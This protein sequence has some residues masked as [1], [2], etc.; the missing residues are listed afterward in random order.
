MSLTRSSTGEFWNDT[1]SPDIIR[2][3]QEY[4]SALRASPV[5]R[6][7]PREYLPSDPAERPAALLAL[8]RVDLAQRWQASQRVSIE[9]YRDRYP[10]L[11]GEA[12]VTLIYEEYCLRE[13][14]GEAPEAAEY[15]DRFPEVAASFRAVLEIHSLIRQHRTPGTGTRTLPTVAAAP[16]SPLP[17]AGETIGGF[18]LVEELGRG[19]FARVFRAEEQQLAD[20]PVA[21]KVTRT[22]SREPQTLARL[23][24][25]HIV[26]V[27]SYRTDLAT[28]LHLLCMPYLGRVTLAR[29]LG[30]RT[31]RN[32]RT[33]ADLALLLDRLRSQGGGNERTEALAVDSGA[34][35]GRTYAGAIAWWGARLA[36]ALQHAHDR[37]VLHRDVK[38][39]NILVTDDGLPM[40]L[41][42]NLAQEPWIDAPHGVPV[43]LGGTLAYM[44]P[45]QL[46][47]LANG[48][49]GW[50]DVNARS[51]LYALGVVLYECLAR[52]ARTFALPSEVRSLAEAMRT[53][54]ALRRMRLP[55]VRDIHPDVPVAF[56]AV[57]ARCLAPDADDR[58]ATAAELATDLQAVAEDAP[59]RFAREPLGSRSVRW[60][61]R[62]RRRLALAAPLLL[63]LVISGFALVRAQMAKLQIAAEV[64]QIIAD[65]IH[66]VDDDQMDL[67]LS[68]FDHAARL[69]ASGGGSRLKRLRD[70]ALEQGKRANRSKA[71]RNSADNLFALGERVRFALLGFGGDSRAACR[72]VETV[73]ERFSVPYNPQWMRQPSIQLLNPARRERLG[74]EVNE[75]LFLW[76]VVLDRERQTERALALQATRICDAALTFAA[77]AAPWRA[78]R[79]RYAALLDGKPPPISPLAPATDESAGSARGCFQWALLC[80]LEGRDEATIAWLERAVENAPNDYWSQFYLGFYD[81]RAGHHQ[82]ALEHYQAAIAIRKDSPWAWYNRAL[83]VQAQGDLNQALGDLNRALALAARQG[84]DFLEARLNLGLVRAG[85]GDALGARTAYESVIAAAAGEPNLSRLARLNRAQLDVESGAVARA[86]REYDALL[87]EDPRDAPARDARLGRA[88]LALRLGQAAAAEDDL[89]I[90]LQSDPKNAAAIFA[91]R[92]LARL[93]LGHPL[94]AEADAASAYRRQPSPNRERLWIRTLLALSRLDDLLWLKSPD[95]LAIL[96]GGDRAL[97]ADFTKALQRL[98]VAQVDG[99]DF[100]PEAPALVHRTRAVLL[101]ALGDPAAEAEASRAIALAPGSHDVYLVRARV[102]RRAGDLKG[103]LADVE[104]G[105]AR[106]PCD[107]RL[108][109]LS[110]LLESETGHPAAAL[111]ILDR[112]LIRGAP[113]SIHA[114]KGLA[115]IALGRGESALEEWSLA[116]DDDPEDPRL[117]LGRARALILLGRWARALADL[118]QAADWAGDHPPLLSRITL[119]SAVCLPARP[120]RFPQ[121]LALARHTFAALCGQLP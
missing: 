14:A 41:D 3:A 49:A 59:L 77:P 20:R 43:M 52:G 38:P 21:M 36:E 22:G 32:A 82:R 28:G 74:S 80:D 99:K 115:L 1:T 10:E 107:P 51:D 12:L 26:P 13:E 75:L 7:E 78:L 111:I 73:L 121:W 88:L 106:E 60:L 18:R 47:A 39:S 15:D 37:G 4:E 85:L 31:I 71:I 2:R 68:R 108:L 33:G 119:A 100:L 54:A 118:D 114:A 95:D 46:E 72:A 44:A 102:R 55:R 91:W 5:R 8:L 23:Q 25:T 93:A 90:A 6:P 53:A 11:D 103:A 50:V 109:E 116:L 30:D 101:S 69:A 120:D 63:A 65:G 84:F 105:L 112:A 34:L 16:A 113:A 45:E 40:L 97:R 62:N 87:S 66:A 94:D 17:E 89:T 27:Y 48:K 98:H 110:G 42:F 96:P 104:T 86:R 64:E 35:A 92:A 70:R 19:S 81:E 67:A 9:W 57:I 76:V 29:V 56:E 58:Y 83:L 24:H 79:A 117:Y 61:R